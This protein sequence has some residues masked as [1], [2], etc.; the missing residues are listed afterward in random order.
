MS[1]SDI[2]SA[3]KKDKVVMGSRSVIKSVKN[4]KTASVIYASNLPRPVLRD[5][6]RYSNISKIDVREFEGNSAELGELLGKPFPV[7]MLGIRK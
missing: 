6:N 4:G 2:K 5:L 1:I 7:L 3:M